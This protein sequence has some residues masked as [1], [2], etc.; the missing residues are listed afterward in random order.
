MDLMTVEDVCQKL[1]VSRKTVYRMIAKGDLPAPRKIGNFR[2][3]YFTRK[4]IEKK[5]AQGLR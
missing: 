4:D 5:V 3:V 1:Q 2:K